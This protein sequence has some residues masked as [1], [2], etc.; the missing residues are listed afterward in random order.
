MQI[1]FLSLAPDRNRLKNVLYGY[2]KNAA[3]NPLPLSRDVGKRYEDSRRVGA[4]AIIF[5][6]TKFQQRELFLQR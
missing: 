3:Y 6:Q 5:A 2:R 4:V 1:T